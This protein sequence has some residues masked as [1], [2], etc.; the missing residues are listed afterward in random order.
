M[1]CNRISLIG[2]IL[3]VFLLN[4]S[5]LVF[6]EGDLVRGKD[7]YTVCTACHGKNGEGNKA[8]NAPANGGQNEWYVVR[9]LK[10]FR[11]GIRGYDPKDTFGTQMRPMAM[12]L[13]DDQAV[14]DVAAYIASL[15]LPDLQ[16]TPAG[17][18]KSGEK[19]Y[20]PCAACHGEKGEGNKSLNAPRLSK[21]HDWYTVRQLKNFKQGIRGS[22]PKDIYGAQMQSMSQLLTTD[23]AVND[24]AAYL[25]TL[26]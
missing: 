16:T 3:F 11:A 1:S 7:L 4:E 25:S 17:N 14:E 24:V 5:I 26:E 13:P 19:A 6:A 18:V 8:L 20:M 12:S 10:N 23:E 21:Q 2:F 9:Q 15:P 22:H